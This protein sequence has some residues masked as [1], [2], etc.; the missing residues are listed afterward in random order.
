MLLSSKEWVGF[1]LSSLSSLFCENPLR[2]LPHSFSP[3]FLTH[4]SVIA[5][6]SLI[7]SLKLSPRS[8]SVPSGHPKKIAY[9]LAAMAAQKTAHPSVPWPPN[10][11][12]SSAVFLHLQSSLAAQ[13]RLLLRV[14]RKINKIK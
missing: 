10:T 7:L 4:L 13:E 3:K 9:L 5:T 6:K 14:A 11:T 1:Q 12:H 8:I 2:L